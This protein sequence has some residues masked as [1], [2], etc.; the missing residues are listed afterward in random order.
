MMCEC[1]ARTNASA[2]RNSTKG[3]NFSIVWSKRYHPANRRFKRKSLSLVHCPLSIIE[4]I[5]PFYDNEQWTSDNGQW[6]IITQSD[7]PV[8]SSVSSRHPSKLHWY[9]PSSVGHRQPVPN[10]SRRRNKE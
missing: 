5:F 9:S 7:S 10:D 8:L 6:A 1:T 2:Y 4:T 3:R